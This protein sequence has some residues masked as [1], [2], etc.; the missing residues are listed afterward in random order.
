MFKTVSS[1][2]RK[3]SKTSQCQTGNFHLVFFSSLRPCT[4]R[5]HPTPTLEPCHSI[6]GENAAL[7]SLEVWHLDALRMLHCG[8]FIWKFMTFSRRSAWFSSDSS[9][10]QYLS[11]SCSQISR[12]S[13]SQ[14]AQSQKLPRC[15][16][17]RVACKEVGLLSILATGENKTLINTMQKNTV[18]FDEDISAHQPSFCGSNFFVGMDRPANFA[19]TKACHKVC[20]IV[21]HWPQ[22]C[23][24]G[25]QMHTSTHIDTVD[26]EFC[27]LGFVDCLLHII[28]GANLQRRH[29]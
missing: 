6:W 5:P 4:S 14:C 28:K 9:D 20:N 29:K 19:V 27:L 3:T 21:Q 17:S 2:F 22:S 12:V 10:L 26:T 16:A 1:Y 11:S 23:E 13:T 15:F 24:R 18:A 25:T 8:L 7:V